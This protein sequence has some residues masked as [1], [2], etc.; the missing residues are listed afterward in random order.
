MTV[1]ISDFLNLPTLQEVLKKDKKEETIS[2][3]EI[4]KEIDEQASKSTAIL[5]DMSA[6][7]LLLE[8]TDHSE[9]MD[10]LHQEIVQHARDLMAY[11]FNTDMR[12]ARGIF[13]VAGQFYGHAIST[14]NSKRDAQ[15]KAIKLAMD[16]KKLDL[17]EKKTNHIIGNQTQVA[18]I[19][20][21][22]VVVEDRNELIKRLREEMNEKND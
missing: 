15:L 16:K 4:E 11:G 22:N 13:E 18:S 14:K 3:E 19:S 6:R 2:E 8:G 7:L 21:G 20:G 9:A 12:G 17:D 1:G 10:E 5:H